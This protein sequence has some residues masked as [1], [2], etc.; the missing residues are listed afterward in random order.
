YRYLRQDK[1]N[2]SRL[3]QHRRICSKPYR[4]R[5]G[6]TWTR[7]KEPNRVGRENRAASVDQKSRIGEWEADSIG[8]KGKKSALLTLVER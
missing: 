3:W 2:G 8:G 5:Y 6:S 4:K 1:S 7:G